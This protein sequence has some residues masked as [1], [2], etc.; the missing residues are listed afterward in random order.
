MGELLD[1]HLSFNHNKTK[2]YYTTCDYKGTA[3]IRCDIY[4][5]DVLPDGRFANPVKLPDFIND[6]NYT[7][8]QPNI[9]YSI[10][11]KKDIL[12]FV[13]DR[14]GGKGKFDIWYSIIDNNGN[15]T[16]PMNLSVIN[17]GENEITPFYHTNTN[18]LYFSSTG[19]LGMGGYDIYASPDQKG[20]FGTP[21]HQGYPLNSSYDDIYFW[22]N[23]YGSKA[24]FSSNREGA[25][26]LDPTTEACC[27]DIFKADIEAIQID[28]QV[29]T[30]NKKTGA[31]LPSVEVLLI[32]TGTDDVIGKALNFG[33]NESNFR[34]VNGKEYMVIAN[35]LGY[36]PDTTKF[37]TRG[38]TRNEKIT[39]KLF[40]TPSE[41]K[42]DVFTYDR[43]TTDDLNGVEVTLEDLTDNTVKKIVLTNELANDFHFDLIRGNRYK[44]TAIK[45]GY[46]S[47]SESI[48]TANVSGKTLRKNLYLAD[49]LNAYLP[50]VVYFDNDRPDPRTVS[51]LTKQKYSDTYNRYMLKKDE[52]VNKYTHDI[53]DEYAKEEAKNNIYDFFDNNVKA[54]KEKFDLFMETLLSVLNAGHTVDIKFKGYASPRADY[55]YNLILANRRVKSLDN[56][57]KAYKNG[58]LLKFIKSGNLK[59]TDISYG[60]SL[61]PE[62]VSSDLNDEKD[63]VYSVPASKERRVEVIK[64]NSDLTSENN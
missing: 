63:S 9:G 52:F 34:L 11:L 53:S 41:L 60:E 48:E 3:E 30:Y 12:Y 24:Y 19:Y 1:A 23:E 20:E 44:V 43:I 56:E 25:L 8:T 13:S 38:I 29:L 14:E 62:N 35:K 7:N 18:T 31:D 54:G 16:K 26:Y 21:M 36:E 42:L 61:A 37:N 59:I 55:D 4:C 17:T 51:R 50:L 49:M 28:L 15:Y 45:R 57:I 64:I 10:F 5:A 33:S 58:A 39:K 47:V 2:A 6:P 32:D 27:Y 40:L 46:E 22:L